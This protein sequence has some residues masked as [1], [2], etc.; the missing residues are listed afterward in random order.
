MMSIACMDKQKKKELRL[1][2]LYNTLYEDYERK[3][4]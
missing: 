2:E 3:G 1:D 4:G